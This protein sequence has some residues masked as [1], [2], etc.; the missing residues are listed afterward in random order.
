MTEVPD[1][2]A[3]LAP[4]P[5]SLVGYLFWMSRPRFWLYLAGPVVV[6]VVYAAESPAAFFSLPAVAAFLYFLVPANVF[7]YGVN[8]IFDA[9]VDTHNPKKDAEGRE[10][11]YRGDGVVV[12][13]V[14]LATALGFLLVFVLPAAGIYALVGFYLLG[15]QY[16]APPLRFKTTPLLDSLS[17]G[18]YVLPGVV[19]Y[20]A[21]AGELPPLLAIVGG[22]LWTM[23]MHT[24]SAVP[25]I[26]P[27]REAGITTTATALGERGALAYCAG[28]WLAAA[29]VMWLV[30]PFLGAVFAGYPL[31]VGGIRAA[32][33]ALDRAYWWF[34]VVNT[35]AGAVL[36]LG[37]IWVVT[38]G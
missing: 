35:L 6:G 5:Q 25:D 22:W 14:Y 31:F 15:T 29:V 9:D 16:S 20:S 38:Y 36:T 37:G 11:R 2:L 23:A 4:S 18:L 7:L 17:N 12:M 19:G 3:A 26:E 10:V 1:R 33:V 13:F 24:F 21:V 34:P 32:D 28:C 8:D 27:D 30:H